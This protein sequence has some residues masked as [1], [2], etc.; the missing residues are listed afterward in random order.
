[1]TA[2]TIDAR[3]ACVE[4]RQQAICDSLALILSE[5]FTRPVSPI[6]NEGR[7]RFCQM[8][9]THNDGCAWVEA[10]RKWR[11]TVS[12]IQRLKPT[13]GLAVSEDND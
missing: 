13:S 8:F 1:M 5:S 3:L 4:G 2:E 11:L 7:C 6:N 10:N 12:I 9:T